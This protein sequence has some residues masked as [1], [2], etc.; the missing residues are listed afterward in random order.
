MA[1]IIFAE[2]ENLRVPSLKLRQRLQ[3]APGMKII[4]KSPMIAK[5]PTTPLLSGRKAFGTINKIIPPSAVTTAE[6]GRKETQ[7]KHTAHCKVE[8]YP[9]IEKFIPYNP[10]DFEKYSIPEDLVCISG[11]ALPGLACFPKTPHACEEDL[12]KLDPLPDYHKPTVSLTSLSLPDYCLELDAFL[13][14][15]EQI[16]E[17]PP[18]P[19]TD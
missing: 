8:E 10:L 17:L 6:G 11:M 16:I 19:V 13:Q 5:T 18:E 3:S 14:T 1:N 7:T 4:L 15:L 2:P 12:E 9:E